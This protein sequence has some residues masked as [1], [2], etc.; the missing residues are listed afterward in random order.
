MIRFG[1]NQIGEGL[2]RKGVGWK[3]R[4][5]KLVEMLFPSAG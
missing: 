4:R 2:D 1:F 5:R 3:D